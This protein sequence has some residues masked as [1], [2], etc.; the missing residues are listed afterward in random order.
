MFQPKSSAMLSPYISSTN[1]KAVVVAFLLGF[2]VLTVNKT[3][4]PSEEEKRETSFISLSII[5]LYHSSSK[6]VPA[7]TLGSFGSSNPAKK[8]RENSSANI[9]I[10]ENP[11]LISAGPVN[12]TLCQLG[13]YG[14]QAQLGG[15]KLLVSIYLN[16]GRIH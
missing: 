3:L 6:A 12:L 14:H 7:F 13:F 9:L 16:H 5:Y 15:R 10:T 2:D 1:G 11:C 4:Q 8:R